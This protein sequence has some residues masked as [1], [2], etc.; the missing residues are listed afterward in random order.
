LIITL[1]IIATVD[2]GHHLNVLEKINLAVRPNPQLNLL[3]R[4][5]A[6]K[7]PN[8][9]IHG[10]NLLLGQNRINIMKKSNTSPYKLA[11]IATSLVM[12]YFAAG[13]AS[14]AQSAELLKAEPVQ[15]TSLIKEAT[16]SLKLSFSTIMIDTN[17]TADDVNVLVSSQREGAT[18]NPVMTISKA[19]LTGE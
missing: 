14:I 3:Q 7:G 4:T 1:R 5:S 2:E 11:I 8:K 19:S 12:V 6:R 10:N 15:K 16:D 9:S 17:I 18:V 13:I